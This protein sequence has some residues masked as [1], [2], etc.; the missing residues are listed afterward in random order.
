MAKQ[1]HYT[2][3]K[4]IQVRFY[5]NLVPGKVLLKRKNELIRDS[6][7]REQTLQNLASEKSLKSMIGLT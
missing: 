6:F 5:Y 7:Q 1:K 3:S 2:L 4:Y